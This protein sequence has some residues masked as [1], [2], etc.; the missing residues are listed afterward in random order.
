MYSLQIPFSLQLACTLQAAYDWQLLLSSAVPFFFLSH[1]N[2]LLSLEEKCARGKKGGGIGGG[3]SI[4]TFC[5][6][7]IKKVFPQRQ[8]CSGTFVR[9]ER[10]EERRKA[11]FEAGEEQRPLGYLQA[12]QSWA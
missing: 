10:A 4:L 1:L 9:S 6:E 7:P 11:A 3:R 5:L 8:K 12:F 2:S